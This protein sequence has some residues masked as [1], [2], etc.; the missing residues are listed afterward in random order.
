MFA[1]R[2]QQTTELKQVMAIETPVRW[3]AGDVLAFSGRGAVSMGIKLG[4]CSAISHVAVVGWTPG[5][6]LRNVA[7][8]GVVRIPEDRLADWKNQYLLYEST[9][10]ATAPCEIT[11]RV[12]TGVQAHEPNS[13][14]ARYRGRVWLYRMTAAWRRDFTPARGTRLTGHLLAR[15]GQQYDGSGAILAGTRVVKHL[16]AWRKVDRSSLFCSEYLAAVLQHVGLFPISNASKVTPASLI[17]DLIA[18]EVYS[19]GVQLKG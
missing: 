4:T 8:S 18:A 5:W 16:W 12:I 10:L 9:T 3:Q 11:G 19:P 17:R 1:N 15:I 13:R 7:A 14:V 6:Q 2:V